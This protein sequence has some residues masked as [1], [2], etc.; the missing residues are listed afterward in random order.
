MLYTFDEIRAAVLLM[1]QDQGPLLRKMRDV[2]IRYEGDW[3]IPMPDVANE[4]KMPQL[5]PA[6]VGEAIDQIAMRAASVQ[7]IITCP[8]LD[9]SKD[10][11]RRSRAY[12]NT[13]TQII[14]ATLERSRWALGRR[15]LYRQLTAYHTGSVVCLPDMINKIPRIEVR[16]P[17]S[18]YIEP[19]AAES[20][21][22]P[23]Y[24]A[25]VTRM[26]GE[27]LRQ[28]FPMVRDDNGGPISNREMQR[29]WEVC[30]W[31][32]NDDC[33]WGLIG[34]MES[35][36]SHISSLSAAQMA[37]PCYMELERLPNRAGVIPMMV[38]HNVSLGGIASRIGS[39]LG[40]V[41]LQAKL[42]GLHIIAQEKA[43]FPDVYVIGR[44][45]AEPEL[46]T[47]EWQD[48]R[49]GN[50]N[51][52]RDAESVGVLRTT[53]DPATNQMIDRLER[54][55]RTSTSLVPQL[56]GET[57]GAMRTGRAIDALSGMA[58]DPRVQEVHE[59]VESY[60]PVL[61]QAILATYKGYWGSK[62]FSMYA[63]HANRRK[64]IEFVPNEHIETYENSV[65]YFSAGADMMQ[66]TQLLGSLRGSDA[67]SQR[68][69]QDA[70]PMIGDS[71]AER[72]Q[73]HEEKLENAALEAVGQQILS[74]QMPPTVAG[75]LAKFMSAGDSVFQ[76]IDKVDT[77]LRELQATTAQAPPPEAGMV[78]P[79]ESMPGLSGGPAADQQPAP[80]TQPTPPPQ[81]VG[82][83]R[84][85]MQAMS[86]QGA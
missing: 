50:I 75:M 64:M 45:S 37:P 10:R 49:T 1:Q 85:L 60:Q 33:V 71:D 79:P 16:D 54:N 24:G 7:P 57:Y 42:M 23:L 63:G 70:H 20:T 74:G 58:L 28:R 73:L 84:Q 62:Q 55:F 65:N 72:R 83:M 31:Y 67:I 53:A 35:Q 25:F 41:D 56:G 2:L 15:R 22:D 36:G 40:N 38:P 18:T 14:N 77:K 51:L 21:R 11:G 69:F 8:A 61:H 82:G 34:P 5:T 43:I 12:A 4:P 6:L 59:I 39:L 44:Q 17:L 46:V 47:G 27:R 26:S 86:P 66:L 13:R 68:T 32:D 29:M 80:F 19:Q 78:G 3:V 81:G 48:G 30:E 76:A 52:I 9:D